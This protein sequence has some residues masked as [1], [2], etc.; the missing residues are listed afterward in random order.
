[1]GHT[2]NDMHIE[3]EQKGNKIQISEDEI[4]TPDSKVIE[5]MNRLELNKLSSKEKLIGS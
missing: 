5:E 3:I 1:M 2:I 4:D